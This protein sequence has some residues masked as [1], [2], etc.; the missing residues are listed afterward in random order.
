MEH[1]IFSNGTVED[2]V[3]R[4]VVLEWL[5][6]GTHVVV[7]VFVVTDSSRSDSCCVGSVSGMSSLFTSLETFF[8]V[9]VGDGLEEEEEEEEDDST[10]GRLLVGVELFLRVLLVVVGGVASSS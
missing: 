9:L 7:I 5:S 1:L 6:I 8:L 10:F 3:D 2:V 4:S